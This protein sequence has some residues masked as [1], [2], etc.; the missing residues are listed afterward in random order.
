M[1]GSFECPSIVVALLR[2]STFEYMLLFKKI[3][4]V[5]QY[6]TYRLYCTLSLWGRRENHSTFYAAFPPITVQDLCSKKQFFC[7]QISSFCQYIKKKQHLIPGQ[8]VITTMTVSITFV[9]DFMYN[10]I[11]TEDSKPQIY[12]TDNN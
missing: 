3:L 12:E 1:K 11:Q 10:Y 9:L 2:F 6:C 4:S 5:S 7:Q 8:L